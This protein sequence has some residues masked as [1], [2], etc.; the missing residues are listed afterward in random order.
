LNVASETV[1][2]R[3]Q[4]AGGDCE[5]RLHLTL[6][7][8]F[9]ASVAGRPVQLR[10][11]RAKALV[12]YL[13]LDD[14][15]RE[16]R[17]R[18]LALLWSESEARKARDSLRQVIK[19]VN[20]AL[21]KAAF[22]GFD[23]SGQT[24]MLDRT[25]ISTDV[26]AVID[27]T[28]SGR[29]HPR[30]LEAKRLADTL[31]ADL[32]GVDSAFQ[33]WVQAKQHVLHERLVL[34]LETALAAGARKAGDGMEI[35][36]ALLNLDPTHEVA[37]RHLMRVYV[38]RGQIGGALQVYKALW[39]LLEDEYDTEPSKET[40]DLIVSIKQQTSWS[41]RPGDAADP[42]LAGGVVSVLAP[43][44][45]PRPQRLFIAVNA[46]DVSGLD[47]QLRSTVSGFRHDL[48]ASLARFR[49]WSVR[50]TAAAAARPSSAGAAVEYALDATAL[51]G[52]AGMRLIVTLADGEG[53]VVWSDQFTL[54][55]SDLLSSQQRI[56]R[57]M[58]VALKVNLTAD[59]QRRMSASAGLSSA[60]YDAWLLGQE[61]VQRHNAQDWA[62]AYEI[63][64]ALHAQAPD[65]SPVVSSLVQL[66]NSRHIVFPGV[67]RSRQVHAAALQQA[68]RAVQLDPQDSRAQLCVAW[69][70]QLVDRT[71]DATLHATL[72]TELNPNDPWT[73]MA[74]AQILAYCGNYARAI[75]LC[76]QSTS[77][78][79]Q[80]T[81][82]QRRYA[83][84]IFFLAARYRDS[85]SASFD[86]LDPSPAFSIWRCA[87]LVQLD[88][89]AQARQLLREV[90]TAAKS[91]WSGTDPADDATVYRWLLHIFPIAVE[92]D[93]ERLRQCLAAA[94]G[95][96]GNEKFR[97][98]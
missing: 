11:R 28:M 3:T 13:A 42:K 94:G 85:V 90:V 39:D 66:S 32:G 52:S 57:A 77:L 40:Q 88:C 98:W 18:M 95:L 24:L 14:T 61:H 31:L 86:G 6:L 74:A 12:A 89:T 45:A 46:F 25:H 65:F 58:A 34:A 92:A 87:S 33:V 79:P 35:A 68:Q 84:A 80:P 56:V 93:W 82:A 53:S 2:N 70:N 20:D 1:P 36:Q 59:R 26:D 21:A 81:A 16:T 91:E 38:S 30:L 51:G 8:P 64:Q 29:V 19:E 7:G 62:E 96:V 10:K 23:L 83:S 17:E 76:V 60:L 63:F 43:L 9:A 54:Q 78:T 41:V 71:E 75:S 15:G 73:L 67:F 97:T 5:G 69:A 44:P 72:A 37:C 49:E 47:E 50:A 55:R 4:P 48:I 22:R 27:A